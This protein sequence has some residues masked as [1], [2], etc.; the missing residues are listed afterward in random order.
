MTSRFIMPFAD[1]G[2]GI[3]PPSGAQLFFFESDGVTPKDTYTTKAATATNS[4]PVIAD[5]VGVFPAIYIA[6]DYLVT[7]KDKND[8]QIFG[9]EPVEELMSFTDN[10][11]IIPFTVLNDAVISTSIVDGNFIYIEDRTAGNGGGGH[12]KVVLA[13]TVTPNTYNIVQCTGSP[14]LALVMSLD[15]FDARNVDAWGV[16]VSGVA[17]DNALAA[18]AAL[19]AMPLVYIL[20]NTY[21]LND[22]ILNIPADTQ[23]WGN[24]KVMGGFETSADNTKV[25]GITIELPPGSNGGNAPLGVSVTDGSNHSTDRVKFITC[26]FSVLN[27]S[28]D[29][30]NDYELTNCK[31]TG[32]FAGVDFVNVVS[33]ANAESTKITGNSFKQTNVYR[34][35]KG[36]SVGFTGAQVVTNSF[37]KELIFSNN[38]VKGSVRSGGLQVIDI[39]SGLEKMVVDSN[40]F[41][42]TGGEQT[43]LAKVGTGPLSAVATKLIVSNNIIESQAANNCLDFQG[44]YGEV[45]EDAP[46]NLIIS[47]N[48]IN[49]TNTLRAITSRGFNRCILSNN[50]VISDDDVAN[51]IAI[52]C[53]ASEYIAINGGILTNGQIS[54]NESGGDPAVKTAS[55]T[56]VTLIAQSSRG[57]SINALTAAEVITITGCVMDSAMFQPVQIKNATVDKIV[58]VGNASTGALGIEN[59]GS[60]ITKLVDISNGWNP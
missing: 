39:Y 48:T 6:G 26:G 40:I 20:D 13:N 10:V 46:Q 59:T 16:A 47:G 23:V 1:V 35:L 14:T 56:G 53:R 29:T 24:G 36:T 22:V 4:N 19:N 57:I 7:L 31:F 37:C 42:I 21:D 5:S 11:S 2:S 44:A 15:T 9:L 52:D 49:T 32:D 25:T 30:S 43:I 50:D 41:T 58:I 51:Y 55:V 18:Q 54:I 45:F 27:S 8:T 60:T 38:L 33:L 12:W 34:I 17:A 3:K 28:L